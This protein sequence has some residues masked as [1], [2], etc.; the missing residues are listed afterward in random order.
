MPLPPVASGANP[1]RD[2]RPALLLLR[3]LVQE[4]TG[5]FFEDERLELMV[6]KLQERLP[7]SGCQS[8]LDYFYLLKYDEK[9][10]AEWRRV[11]DAF[12]VQET[13]FWREADQI[14]A[15]VD[16]LVPAWFKKNATPLHIWSAAC[17]SGEEPYSLAIA[18]MEGGWGHHP[19]TIHASDG[20]EAALTKA[21][22]G[23]FRERSFRTL[24][25]ELRERYFT[26]QPT[27]AALRADI[28]ARVTFRWANLADPA[29]FADLPQA[30]VIFCR[31]VFI[32]FSNA[33]IIRTVDAFA[34]QMP[35]E[36]SL[37]IGSSE[38]LLKLTTKFDLQEVGNAFVYVR[39]PAT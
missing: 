37:F 34:R 10:A 17:A 36:G 7:A 20:S 8:Y 28:M 38:S 9:G 32:Y 26:P 22:Q 4:K 12:S 21:R 33:A 27:G 15:V 30:Q 13:Y 25:Q 29:T 16:H 5:V 18:L 31:N 2:Q 39:V 6:D 14:K 19:I 1:V 24:P 23:I 11:M 3:D 35:S